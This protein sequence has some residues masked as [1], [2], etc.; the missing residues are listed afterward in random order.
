[1]RSERGQENGLHGRI[2]NR[3]AGSKRV[4]GGAGRSR[5]YHAVADEPRDQHAA[6]AGNEF[7]GAVGRAHVDRDV[8][9]REGGLAAVAAGKHHPALFGVCA[10]A[11]VFDAGLRLV[12]R[13]LSQ[14]TQSAE[15]H[16]HDRDVPAS[17]QPRG[18]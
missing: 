13:E 3:A 15:V 2:D 8:V 17:D 11:E 10:T 16:A 4:G 14:E 12:S 6:G 9:Q 5:H 18:P 1:M 7:D